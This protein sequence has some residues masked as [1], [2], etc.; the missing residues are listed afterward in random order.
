MITRL[1]PDL[2]QL[3]RPDGRAG[4]SRGGH[5]DAR[6]AQPRRDI[7]GEAIALLLGLGAGISPLFLGYY[8]AT[9]WVPL[10]L[11]IVVVAALAAIRRPPHFTRRGAVSLA[12]IIGLGLL[13]LL[14]TAWAGSVDQATV[15]AD[16]WLVLAA[17]LALTMV[18]VRSG[19][20]ERAVVAGLLVG[21][22]IV[23]SIVTVRMLGSDGSD[24][25]FVGRLQDPLGYI[26]AEATMFLMAAWLC[27]G[28]VERRGQPVVAGLGM[29]GATWFSGLVLL[30]QS[31]GS[32]VAAVASAVIVLVVAPGRQRR[33]FALLVLA[34]GL[35]LARSTLL[36]VYDAAQAAG[37]FAPPPDSAVKDAA[38]TLLL[39]A[40]AIGA[41]WAVVVQAVDRV[42][43]LAVRDRLAAVG[44]IVLLGGA[45]LAIAAVVTQS[46]RI[47]HT[48]DRQ[49]TVF[50]D[51]KAVDTA[52]STPTSTRL[53][54]GV[55]NRYDYWRVAWRTFRDHPVKGIGAGNFDQVWFVERVADDDVRQPHSIE[56][57]T[58]SELGLPGFALLL[59]LAGGI[60]VGAARMLPAAPP[61]S[62]SGALFVG[63]LGASSA[64]AVH[65][66][67]DWQH[68]IPGVIAV[69]LLLAGIFL[70]PRPPDVTLSSFAA[71]R[72]PRVALG[73]AAAAIL[74]LTA[75][76]LTRQLLA[77]HYRGRAF[78]DV[79]TNP[80]RAVEAADKSLQLNDDAVRTYYVKAAALARL[81]RGTDATVTLLQATRREPRESVT[82]A[83]LGDVATRR[84][85]AA[86]ARRYYR[87]ALALNPNDRGLQQ[88]VATSEARKP[89]R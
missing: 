38:T 56:L 18:V 15:E 27:L 9:T 65:T 55:G 23:G 30:C 47:A 39:A 7:P 49:W 75:G 82:W 84:G 46:G 2:E 10:G 17:L 41:V 8:G 50:T 28:A 24:L 60:A 20:A 37:L 83:L 57:Q 32:A 33:C 73:C 4:R 59:M 51:I 25:F 26:N 11:G 16:R 53:V 78:D 42:A 89:S 36:D 14:S 67:V 77:D 64:F 66:S 86:D 34:G 87:R 3:R 40:A 88:L 62:V 43:S 19:R 63:G 74:A 81:G 79:A 80:Q 71:G 12:G 85:R 52:S 61:G 54:S 44:R 21:I 48:V 22:G 31:R 45:V 29:A 68:V 1:T 6:Q 70:R 76:L 72:L 13:A 5:S 35:M 69:P 58:L